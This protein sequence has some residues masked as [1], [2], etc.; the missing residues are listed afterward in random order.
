MHFTFDATRQVATLLAF[1]LGEPGSNP[2]G[3]GDFPLCALGSPGSTY[4]SW[5]KMSSNL[6]GCWICSEN[7]INI[8]YIISSLV[9]LWYRLKLYEMLYCMT[10]ITIYHSM[11]RIELLNN[12]KYFMSN[13]LT[14]SEVG[15][16]AQPRLGEVN[17]GS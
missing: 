13:I 11:Y 7:I 6:N 16:P 17:V 2:G 4:T 3:V 12:Y 15:L 8:I 14:M 10:Q 5:G 1:A 9:M